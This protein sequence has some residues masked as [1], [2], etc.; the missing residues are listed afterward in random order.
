MNRRVRDPYARWCERLSPSDYL[1]GQSTRLPC[2]LK[3]KN[4]KLYLITTNDNVD[5]DEYDAIVVCA[6]SKKRAIEIAI[7]DCHNFSTNV[8]TECLGTANKKQKEGNIL[9]SFNAG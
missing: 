8:T 2:V 6:K 3:L 1:A 5:Y 7:N 9:A 4:M